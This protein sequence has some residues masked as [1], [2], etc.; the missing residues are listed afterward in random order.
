M[1]L[2]ILFS[3]SL[4]G[5]YQIASFFFTDRE[6]V[7]FA[8]EYVNSDSF[9]VIPK[10]EKKIDEKAIQTAG[11]SLDTLVSFSVTYAQAD[12]LLDA[13]LYPAGLGFQRRGE[14]IR[15]IPLATENP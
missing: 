6:S 8:S 5:S 9:N 11:R 4:L 15:I 2:V 13:L 10:I 7:T 3:L 1:I 12:Q 14:R